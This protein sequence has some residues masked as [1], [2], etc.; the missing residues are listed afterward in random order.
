M[1]NFL[2]MDE[3]LAEY[4]IVWHE[5][6]LSDFLCPVPCLYDAETLKGMKLGKLHSIDDLWIAS[7]ILHEYWKSES[8]LETSKA[9]LKAEYERLV[10]VFLEAGWKNEELQ[11]NPL[12]NLNEEL[13]L[14]ITELTREEF[15]FECSMNQGLGYIYL[16]ETCDKVAMNALF[17]VIN[18]GYKDLTRRAVEFTEGGSAQDLNQF[19]WK[20][21]AIRDWVL[22]NTPLYQFPPE[23]HQLLAPLYVASKTE[24]KEAGKVIYFMQHVFPKLQLD[25]KTVTDIHNT[26]NSAS[27]K[28]PKL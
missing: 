18:F 16:F 19:T 12:L 23:V 26:I 10:R 4:S 17:D 3:T 11:E 5:M 21:G 25:E 27:A 1:K 7:G 15:G 8:E 9:N 28:P 6:V 22:D 14:E 20:L 13:A 2:G 24:K